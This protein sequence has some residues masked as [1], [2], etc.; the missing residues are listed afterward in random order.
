M[1]TSLGLLVVLTASLAIIHII[2]AQDQKG[3]ISLDCGLPSNESPY[4]WTSTGLWFYSDERFTQGGKTGRVRENPKGFPKQYDTLRYFPD[5]IRNCYN[6][7]VEKGL[8]YM[9]RATFVYG[10][11]DGRDMKPVFDLHLGPNLWATIDLQ[12]TDYSVKDILHIATSNSIQICLVKTGV[13]GPLISTLEL[14][15]MGIDSYITESGSLDRY[16]R[17]Y[18]SK[19]S[20]QQIRYS[21]DIYDRIWYPLF[22]MGCTQI[23]NAKN[24]DNSN[25]YRPPEIA[26][27]TAVTP[28]NSSEPLTIQWSSENPDEKYYYY[29]HF[30]EIEDLQANET[31]EFNVTWNGIQYYGPLVPRRQIINTISSSSPRTCD[32]GKCRFQLIRTDKSTR[33]PLLNAFEVYTVIQFPQS[34]T[35][36]SDVGAIVRIA[37]TYAL[38][39]INW[40][41]DPRVP[42]QFRWDGLKCS[43]TNMSTPPRITTLNLSS[44]GLAGTIAAAVQNLTQLETLDL[45]NN[46]LTGGVPDFLGNMKALLVINLSRN[47]LT[48]SI[49][50]ALQREGLKLLVE[51]NPRLCLSD[52]CRKQH[53]K[54]KIVPTVASVASAAIVIAVLV[55][56]FVLKKG[57]PAILQGL[58]LLPTTSTTNATFAEKNSRR[59]TYS[60]VDL[61]LRVHHTNLVSLVGYCYEG[62]QLALVYEFLPNGDLKQHL[63]GKGGRS[64]INWSTRLQIALEAASGF[65]SLDCG[66]PS[67]ES[68]YKGNYTGLWFYSDEKF[69]QGGKSGRVRENPVG[70]AKQYNTLRYFPD[71]IRNCYNLSVEKGLR[72][73]VR[74]TFAYGNYDGL[75]REPVFDL[76]FG[77]NLWATID[78]QNVNGTSKDMLHVA[79]SNSMQICLVKTGETNPL[80]SSLELRPMRND[81][82]VIKSG[83][84]NLNRHYYLSDSSSQIRYSNDVY[85]RIW[86]PFF[87]KEWTQISTSQTVGNSNGLEIP[88]IALQTAATPTNSS[89]P[90]TIQ[91]TSENPDEKYYYYAHFAEIEDLQANETREFNVTWNGIHSY[92]PFVPRRRLINTIFTQAPITCNGVMCRFEL[93]RTNK[94]TRPP[95]LNA[96]EVYTVIQFPQSETDESDVGA[97]KSITNTYA[98][99]R[100]TWQGDPC[101]PQEFRWDGLNCSNTNMSMPPRITALNLSSSGLAGTIAAA[102]QNLTQLETLNLSR[103]NLSGSI[104][105]VLQREGLQLLFEGNPRLCLSDS[106]KKSNKKKIIVPIVA[107]VASA[108][109]V[110]AVLVILFVL[111]KGKPAIL[112]RG[113]HLLH[114]TSTTDATFAE[115]NSRRFTYSEVIKMTNNFQRVLG[116]GGFGMVYHGS[117][118]GSEQ[119]AVKVLS[120]SSTQGYKEFKAEVDLLLRV[121]HTNLVSLVGYCYEGDH[122]ALIY[123]FLPN[124]DLKQHLSG[125]G[126]RSIIDWST[127]LQ[128]ALEAASG[129][130]YLHIGCIPP[131][132]HRDV[133]TANILLDA[134]LKAKLADFGLSRSFQGGGES[135]DTA[136]AGTPGYLDPEYNHSGRL[137]EKSDVYSFGIVLLEMI[138]NQPVINQ[139]SEKSHITQWVGFKLNQ[140]DIV[141]IMDPNLHKDCDFNSAWRALELAMSCANP[142]SSKR[143]SMSQVIHEIKECLVCAKSG[144]GRNLEL[145]PQEIMSSD[146]SMVPIAR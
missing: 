36:E 106:C 5:G 114:R 127:R 21:S 71:G 64:V 135:H 146:T 111:E 90:L 45:S 24:V 143:P 73:V 58:H 30:A 29:A 70:Y 17:Y 139:T 93:I 33:P 81:S 31:R 80:I 4:N 128:I 1:H 50:Q 18:F 125:K 78:L 142:S 98:L 119:V 55:L 88:E 120:Q 63:S 102:I 104:P 92:G 121:H 96:L 40:Q 109:I 49:P 56:L 59:F 69:A 62:D 39:R 72:Y 6:L 97:I 103:N 131:M 110:I 132:V 137:G 113:L 23:S 38:S 112:L 54:N 124:G 9:V 126:G 53:K 19:S 47:N 27:K 107:S 75:R 52:S 48:G 51:G 89:A 3:F 133:K 141:E 25:S 77:P 12:K 86:V 91:W 95:L 138:T 65:I 74:A 117:V 130:E 118:N 101:V 2:Q 66:L 79:T 32:G 83:S 8:R 85:D 108:A 76:H 44:S 105:Q 13:T 140:G 122:L 42:Q 10:N 87:M 61:L 134:N 115:K 60:E 20:S 16:F 57:K 123:E 99:S 7:S 94:S 11:Y 35:D 22:L 15:P 26:L 68:P 46:N 84:L 82:Y 34:E 28:T 100:I 14:R 145:E 116:K 136:V 144:I 67:N 129:L 37:E 41:G 43:N